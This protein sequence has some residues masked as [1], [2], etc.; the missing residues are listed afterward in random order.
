MVGLQQYKCTQIPAS[1]IHYYQEIGRAG[2]D[3]KPTTIILFYN[4]QKDK[5]GIEEDY[6]LPKAF[7][8]GARPSKEKYLK[9]IEALKQEPLSE[10]GRKS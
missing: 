3:D 1:P 10:W 6:K 4:E 2:R 5:N 8:D 9:A 7:I